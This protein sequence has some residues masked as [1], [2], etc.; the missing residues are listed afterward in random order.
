MS[1]EGDDSEKAEDEGRGTEAIFVVDS[2]QAHARRRHQATSPL[3]PSDNH[4][5]IAG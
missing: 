1:K 5:L 4:W 3:H 2:A